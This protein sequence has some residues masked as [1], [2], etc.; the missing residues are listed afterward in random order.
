MCGLF[1]LVGFVFPPQRL[2]QYCF[3]LSS[4]FLLVQASG[5]AAS[6]SEA[7]VPG[8]DDAPG[9][10]GSDAPTPGIIAK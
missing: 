3:D 1:N 5:S 6:R 9:P 8:A 4:F 7:A 2:I 10:F